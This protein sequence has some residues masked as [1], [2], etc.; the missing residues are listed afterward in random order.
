M[1]MFDDYDPEREA[2]RRRRLAAAAEQRRHQDGG[3]S[4][5]E[6]SDEGEE[7]EGGS[8]SGSDEGAA[9]KRAVCSG[10]AS[11]WCGMLALRCGQ[12]LK[13][14]PSSARPTNAHVDSGGS[15]DGGG[16]AGPG[17][18][19]IEQLL[20]SGRKGLGSLK[21][22]AGAAGA[23]AGKR[24][25]GAGASAPSQRQQQQGGREERL[26]A[27]REAEAEAGRRAR[28]AFMSAKA[29]KVFDEDGVVLGGGGAGRDA[30]GVSREEFQKMAREVEMLGA[31]GAA[32]A[33]RGAL[34]C[35]EARALGRLRASSVGQANGSRAP[36][37]GAGRFG[38]RAGLWGSS[39]G[40][41]APHAP[42]P[43]SR[44]RAA[45]RRDRAGQA[46][47]QVVEGVD[48]QAHRRVGRKGAPRACKN[49][50]GHGQGE[51]NATA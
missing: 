48:A 51:H 7:A 12:L 16:E 19:S 14:P 47:A 29:S 2:K 42:S 35:A 18:A 23:G 46:L 44:P 43:R 25:P 28:K 6:E 13:A 20:Y 27:Q 8:G 17:P 45:R 38:R 10:R 22:M 15:G 40:Q 39:H 1:S 32:A 30:D 41:A 11:M 49:F 3:G 26:A 34:C 33:G 50:Q 4:G 37:A 21:H 36:V 24:A 5:S 9:R 31:V